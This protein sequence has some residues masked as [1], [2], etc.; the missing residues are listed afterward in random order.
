MPHL[1]ELMTH[2]RLVLRMGRATGTD[3]VAAHRQGHLTQQ[4]WADMIQNCRGCEWANQCPDW[5]DQH[6]TVPGAPQPCRNRKRF[7]ALK[8]M[9]EQVD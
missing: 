2:L 4:D 6:E 3:V 1:G 5:L 8:E 7:A 9:Q